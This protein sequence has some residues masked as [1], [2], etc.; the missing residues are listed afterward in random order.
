MNEHCELKSIPDAVTGGLMARA[1]RRA[2]H[3]ISLLLADGRTG[4]YFGGRWSPGLIGEGVNE[5]SRRLE[6]LRW[7]FSMSSCVTSSLKA[8]FSRYHILKMMPV[9]EYEAP[10]PVKTAFLIVRNWIVRDYSMEARIR[11]VS[12]VAGGAGGIARGQC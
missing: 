8:I 11:R 10:L 12:A 3:M 5:T 6:Q 1:R 2:P 4:S 9:L 7:L